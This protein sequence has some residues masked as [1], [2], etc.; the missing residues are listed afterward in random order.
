MQLSIRN[1]LAGVIDSVTRGEVMGMVRTRLSGGQEVVSAITLEAVDDLKLAEGRAVTV[2]LKST[3]VAIATGSVDGLSIRNRIPG[4]IE[5]VEL[6][7]VM[8][9][10]RVAIAGGQVITSAITK[11]AAEDLKLAAGG[12]VTVLVKATDAS[13]AVD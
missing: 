13:I 8:T 2:L 6:G 10:V 4:T 7:A 12:A 9:T 5:D 1:Q 3:E 11:E